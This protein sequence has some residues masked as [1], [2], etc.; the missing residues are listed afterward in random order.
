MV[1][2][3]FSECEGRADLLAAFGDVQGQVGGQGLAT[4]EQVRGKAE[5]LGEELVE[6]VKL[7]G[8]ARVS[9]GEGSKFAQALLEGDGL[10][11][12]AA[13][14]DQDWDG[15]DEALDRLDEAEPGLVKVDFDVRHGLSR[16]GP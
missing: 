8:G 12:H 1:G 11:F 5:D 6:V 2:R 10:P 9:A 14:I 16:R 3:L 13:R 15:E 7:T 4:V